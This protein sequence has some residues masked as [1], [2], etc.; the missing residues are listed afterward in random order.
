MDHVQLLL[1]SVRLR[2]TPD[3]APRTPGGREVACAA[4][5]PAGRTVERR[6]PPPGESEGCVV[7]RA[8]RVWPRKVILRGAEGWSAPN[9]ALAKSRPLPPSV[10][11]SGQVNSLAETSRV[12]GWYPVVQ[13]LQCCRPKL[14]DCDPALLRTT[15]GYAMSVLDDCS[16]A[17]ARRSGSLQGG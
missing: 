4:G 17:A 5:R 9:G 6:Q 10:T 13:R 11:T 2:A 3:G 16:R 12:C 8:L 15:R 7:E 14:D 1:R